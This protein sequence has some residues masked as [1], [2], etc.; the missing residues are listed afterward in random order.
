MNHVGAEMTLTTGN[1]TGTSG[2]SWLLKLNG[3]DRFAARPTKYFTRM[4][5]AAPH[6]MWWCS[7]S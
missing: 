1:G 7:C 6:W 2:D 5:M 3:H 4:G